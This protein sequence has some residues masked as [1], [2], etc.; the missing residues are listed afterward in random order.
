MKAINKIITN[1]R[2]TAPSLTGR[3]CA[4]LLFAGLALTSCSD[5]FDPSPKG[6]MDADDSFSEGNQTYKGM[7]GVINAVQ[8]A[9][10]HAI[11]LTDTRMNV[12]ETTPN[13][14]AALQSIYKYDDTD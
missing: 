6:I 12:L 1:M 9:G 8:Q 7:L 13:A 3:V 10:D 14:P 11:F 4:G 5:Y 2:H